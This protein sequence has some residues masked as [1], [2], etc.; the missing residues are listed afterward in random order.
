M[1]QVNTHGQDALRD[2]FAP[3]NKI[4][5]NSSTDEHGLP[6]GNVGISA[7]WARHR[8]RN[9]IPNIFKLRQERH[10]PMS[11]LRSWENESG[12]FYKDSAPNGA[13]SVRHFPPS[14]DAI[15]MNVAFAVPKRT[16]QR[17]K[18]QCGQGQWEVLRS[19]P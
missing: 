11:L 16:A 5:T 12:L 8:C 10:I 17:R 7:P 15:E 4:F 14:R 9:R 18:I 2:S 19:K 13:D 3:E 1:R 6:R